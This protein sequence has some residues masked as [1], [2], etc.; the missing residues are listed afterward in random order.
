MKPDDLLK[1]IVE[2]KGYRGE[3]AK[4][5]KETMDTYWVPGVNH[6]G[7]YGRWAFAEFAD[8]FQMQDDFA[9]IGVKVEIVSYEW[10]EYLNRSK[11]K[12]RDGA[13]MLGWTGDNGD[14]DNWLGTLYSCDAIGG[15]N[16]SMWCDP[17]YDKLIKQAKVVTDREQRTVL[18]KQA[19]QLLKQQVPITPVAHSTVNQPLSARIEGFKVSPF[20]RNVFSGVGID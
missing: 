2:I 1:L 6:L 14:P 17:A 12:D 5:K 11:A 19:Q 20:G 16:Y 4:I 8:V 9:K 7:T 3:D 15:N 13:V 18:Y 10:A